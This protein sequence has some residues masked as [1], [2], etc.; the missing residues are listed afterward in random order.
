M[1]NFII[2]KVK[3]PKTNHQ[4]WKKEIN[5]SSEFENLLNHILKIDEIA[6]ADSNHIEHEEKL[7]HLYIVSVFYKI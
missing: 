1:L 3:H 6:H 7:E 5:V 4:T 2:N